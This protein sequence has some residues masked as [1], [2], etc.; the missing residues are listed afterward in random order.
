MFKNDA[1]RVTDFCIEMT[2]ETHTGKQFQNTITLNACKYRF[3][4]TV[5][6]RAFPFEGTQFLLDQAERIRYNPIKAIKALV[7]TFRKLNPEAC[8]DYTHVVSAVWQ[9]NM[10]KLDQYAGFNDTRLDFI[11]VCMIGSRAWTEPKSLQRFINRLQRLITMTRNKAKLRSDF[12]EWLETVKEVC[13]RRQIIINAE[14]ELATHNPDI[15]RR[16]EDMEVVIIRYL[17]D[18]YPYNG[19][20]ILIQTYLSR[21]H[22]KSYVRRIGASG[23]KEI[24][25]RIARVEQIQYM[26]NL[27]KPRNTLGDVDMRFLI[28]LELLNKF[29]IAEFNQFRYYPF[30]ELCFFDYENWNDEGKLYFLMNA[31]HHYCTWAQAP[32]IHYLNEL[33]TVCNKRSLY[34]MRQQR[35]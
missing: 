27:L 21:L 17:G 24:E 34:L 4:M 28:I 31:I 6:P 33:L 15:V 13:L 1:T 8:Q 18:S 20:N 16:P 7:E 32:L 23:V 29:V 30:L 5:F 9:V 25:K 10:V 11:S 12:Y 22:D 14:E 26:L 3:L 35:R 2:E 19:I